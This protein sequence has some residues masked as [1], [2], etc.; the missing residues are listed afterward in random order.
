MKFLYA[1]RMGHVEALVNAL[2]LN[3]EKIVT[4]EETVNEDYILFTYTDGHGIVPAVVESFLEKN[5]ANLKGVIASGS[6]ERHKDTFCWAGDIISK[7]YGV[8][9]LYKVDGSGTE[10]DQR[11]IADLLK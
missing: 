2:N 9:C 1:S 4:G 8:P 6:M 3:A 7:K 11:K 5:S 10:E